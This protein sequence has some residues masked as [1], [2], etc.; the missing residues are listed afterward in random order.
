MH[1][2]LILNGHAQVIANAYLSFGT[3]T[4]DFS[5]Q[6]VGPDQV[7]AITGWTLQRLD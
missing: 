1:V 6:H 5:S 7:G 4:G 3:Q 2:G